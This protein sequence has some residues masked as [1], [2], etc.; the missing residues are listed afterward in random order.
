MALADQLGI[1]FRYRDALILGTLVALFACLYIMPKAIAKLRGAGIVGRDRHKEGRPEIP[2]MGGLGV[3]VAYMMGAFVVIAISDLAQS[4]LVLVLAALV[5]IAGATLTGALDD[6][7]VLRQRFKAA[8]PFAFAAPLA[9]FVEDTTIWFPLLG[10][11][12][13]GIWYPLVLVPVGV[14]CA[15]NGFNM[16]EGFN[17]LGT[18]LG[19]ILGLALAFIVLL[20]GNPVGLALLA[21]LLGALAGFWVFNAYPARVFPGDTMTLMVGAVIACAAIIGKVEFWGALLLVP[22]IVEFFL[23]ATS[24]FEAESFADRQ[25]DGKQIHEGSIHS[26]P[27]LAMKLSGPIREDHLVV[28]MHVAFTLFAGLVTLAAF[29][30]SP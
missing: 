25:E 16:L 3:F 7:I 12:D 27:H 19:I 14:A 18:G 20:S 21:P 13:F 23:K 5:V 30:A 6:L 28:R 10:T 26:L 17:G 1:Q 8:L 2:E 9:L 22:H 24:R 4:D 11:V 15:S 29:A